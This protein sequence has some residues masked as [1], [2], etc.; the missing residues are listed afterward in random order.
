MVASIKN[1]GDYTYR[2]RICSFENLHAKMPQSSLPVT[3]LGVKDWT[4]R[5]VTSTG[6]SGLLLEDGFGLLLEDGDQ[7]LLE[8]SVTIAGYDK[9]EDT[10]YTASSISFQAAAGSEPA[11]I[12]DSDYKFAEKLIKAHQLI[13]IATD[14][15]TNDRDCGIADRGVSRGEIRLDIDLTTE[16]AA[17]AGTVIISRLIDQPNISTGCPLCGSMNSRP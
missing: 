7:L 2:C 1:R 4:P 13:R 9:Y 14:S 11:K 17:A 5:V 16:S 15:G 12:L 8:D 10:L 6:S 3:K